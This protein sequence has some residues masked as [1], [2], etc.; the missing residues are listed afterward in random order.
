MLNAKGIE[1]GGSSA[2]IDKGSRKLSDTT[3]VQGNV[4][5]LVGKANTAMLD[6]EVG[7]EFKIR[8]GK[9]AIRLIPVGG[10]EE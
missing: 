6:L 3:K 8:L 9:K 10:E 5:R 4:K 7:D 1:L 2:G